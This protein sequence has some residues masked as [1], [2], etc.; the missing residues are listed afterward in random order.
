VKIKKDAYAVKNN[1]TIRRVNFLVHPGFSADPCVTNG[2]REDLEIHF[3]KYKEKA[4]S[5]DKNELLVVLSHRKGTELWDDFKS[6]AGYGFLLAGLF[7]K[8]RVAAGGRLF[9]F[10]DDHDFFERYDTDTE[11]LELLKAKALNK[12]FII[13]ALSQ[14]IFFGEELGACVE[15]AAA[16]IYSTAYF[17]HDSLI[18]PSLCAPY[19]YCESN[20]LKRLMREEMALHAGIKY[21]L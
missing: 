20:Q 12:G 9:I 1:T 3:R 8:L 16:A 17:N 5:L 6:K 14:P 7:R 13:D 10:S 15:D 2:Q 11:T 18:I 21:D 19:G 4:E